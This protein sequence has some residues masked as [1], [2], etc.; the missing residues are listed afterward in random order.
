MAL[1]T[2]E[3]VARELNIEPDDANYPSIENS[4][5][6]ADEYI[7]ETC[8][9][10]FKAVTQTREFPTE[11][12]TSKVYIGDYHLLTSVETREDVKTPWQTLA[13]DEYV[14]S[15]VRQHVAGALVRPHHS[16]VRLD[17]DWPNQPYAPT[18]RVS[19]T[20]GW[21]TIP[22]AVSRAATILASRLVQHEIAIVPGS[23]GISA[24]IPIDFGVRT[25]LQPYILVL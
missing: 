7:A 5:D 12:Y 22:H 25:L 18:V 19:A 13:S 10:E 11:P 2:V 24:A 9:R 8:R 6:A 17:E 20:W 15:P 23:D 16:L 14:E 3:L 1:T 4:V 21:A